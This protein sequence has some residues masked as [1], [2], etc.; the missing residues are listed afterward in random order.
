MKKTTITTTTFYL[1]RWIWHLVVFR[2]GRQD[3][4]ETVYENGMLVK[5]YTFAQVRENA[6]IPL[7][8]EAKKMAQWSR[9]SVHLRARK[10]IL[11]VE[12]QS[13]RLELRLYQEF[14]NTHKLEHSLSVGSH[15]LM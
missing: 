11:G 10:S 15:T 4:L 1:H 7:V 8:K 13:F 6:E 14:K 3:L 5:E 12:S 9:D 2:H